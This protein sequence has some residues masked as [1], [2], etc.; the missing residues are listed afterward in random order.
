MGKP[1]IQFVFVVVVAAIAIAVAVVVVLLYS[2]TQF[3]ERHS[4][5]RE[6]SIQLGNVLP[7]LRV[8]LTITAGS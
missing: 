5:A 7:P 3:Q 4:V 6:A 2:C 1:K 8:Q